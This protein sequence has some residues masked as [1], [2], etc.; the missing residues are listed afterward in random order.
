MRHNILIISL[1]VSFCMVAPGCQKEDPFDDVNNPLSPISLDTRQDACNKSTKD[2]AYSLLEAVEAES[3]GKDYFLSPL[4][5]EFVLGM[6]A[7]GCVGEARAQISEALGAEDIDALNSYAATMLGKLP[8]MDKKTKLALANIALFDNKV[9]VKDG[10]KK[11]LEGKYLAEVANKDFSSG[12]T[13]S[14]INNWASKQTKGLIKEVVN[15]QV[16]SGQLAFLA[17]A[18]Y[19]KSVWSGFKFDKAKRDFTTA[20]GKKIKVDMLETGKSLRM[21]G[22]QRHTVLTVPFGNKA[23]YFNIYLPDEGVKISEMI[24]DMRNPTCL[25]ETKNTSLVRF[26][27]FKGDY[28]CDLSPVLRRIGVKDIFDNADF[29][30]MTS[31]TPMRVSFIKQKSHIDVNETGAEAAAVTFSGMDTAN[32]EFSRGEFIADRPFL[33]SITEYSTGAILFMGKYAGE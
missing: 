18:T 21:T 13:V 12:K 32:I 3:E 25:V 26:P 1:L 29:S 24:H 9:T 20:K 19:F 11:V 15:D 10:F 6:I 8:S 7:N 17:N 2:F 5:V 22:Y 27:K 31:L 16:L 14:Y 33:Y 28:D 4:S 23:F 30:E